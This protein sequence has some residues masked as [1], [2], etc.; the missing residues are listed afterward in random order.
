MK[1][2][3]GEEARYLM[4]E[5]EPATSSI[6]TSSS[7]Y[8]RNPLFRDV[9]AQMGL[10]RDGRDLPSAYLVPE[11]QRAFDEVV[12]AGRLEALLAAERRQRPELAD[13]LDAR[14]VSRFDAVAL[15]AHG[16]GTLGAA[17][18]GFIADS[19]MEIDFMF[20]D[21]AQT[22][23]DYLNK[24]R[25]Q[26]H[27]IEHMVTGFD[28]SPVGEIALIVANITAN[29]A[30]FQDETAGELNRFGVFLLSTSLMRAGLHYPKVMPAYLEGI[31]RARA[32]GR[33]QRLPLFMIRWEDY[34][35]WPMVEIRRHFQFEDG[36]EPG[37]WAWTHDAARD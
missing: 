32:L 1:D 35:D 29:A 8:L 27:D 24:R 21:A 7:V 12:P 5:A 34:L 36:P 13:W 37:A 28:P 16:E 33:R 19:G 25:V 3:T 18:R 23:L 26:V 14:F 10:K 9:Y 6:L 4:G 11:I 30:Y 17:V 22:D 2:G 15:A 31:A 20:R